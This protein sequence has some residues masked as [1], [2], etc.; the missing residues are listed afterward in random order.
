M[1]CITKKQRTNAFYI[2]SP[3]LQSVLPI[4]IVEIITLLTPQDL[5]NV[6]TEIR[7]RS[8][9]GLDARETSTSIAG[10]ARLKA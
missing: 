4:T 10:H 2:Q 7:I 5:A 6:P 9:S 1:I 8:A 3:R